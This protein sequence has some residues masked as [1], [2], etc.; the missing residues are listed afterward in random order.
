MGLPLNDALT[1]VRRHNKG[2]LVTTRRDGR[3]QLSNI[4]YTPGSD[5]SVRISVTEG[6]A[7][8]KNLRRDPRAALHVTRPDFF[9]YVVLDGEVALSPTVRS[10]GDPV[11]EELI[12]MYRLARGEHP[13][14]D[15]FRHGMVSEGRVVA[16]LSATY[17]YGMLG[18]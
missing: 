13:D 11:V 1:F 9:A 17:A 15:E 18:D 2:V 8:T 16:T 7:K 14:W 12:D 5:Y 3:P 4:M 10:I 6:R